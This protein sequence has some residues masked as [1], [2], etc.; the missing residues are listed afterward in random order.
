MYVSFR[1]AKRIGDRIG[2]DWRRYA[3]KQ[4]RA[5]MAVELEH[6]RQD[7]QTDVTH[8]DLVLTGKIAFAHLK[9]DAHYY[10][11]LQRARL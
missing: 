6:G 4:F 9:E 2:V 5:G 10:T 7:P 3:L 1:T 8:D 11:K